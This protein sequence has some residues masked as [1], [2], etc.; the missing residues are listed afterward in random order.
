MHKTVAKKRNSGG[1]QELVFF[2]HFR[3]IGFSDTATKEET[4]ETS[5]TGH[6]KL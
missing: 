3:K 2:A 6:Q 4:G 1:Q 5:K